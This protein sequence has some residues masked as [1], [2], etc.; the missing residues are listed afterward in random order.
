MKLLTD[1]QIRAFRQFINAHDFFYLIGHKEPDGDCICSCVA[2]SLLIDSLDKPFQLLSAGPFKRTEI[3]KYESAFSNAMQF[4]T[5]NERRRSALIMVDCSEYSRLGDIEGDVKNLDTCVIDHHKTA[6]APDN[7]L[8]F[9]DVTAPSTCSI[10]QQ[11]YE[12]VH[13][14]VPQQ[15]AE[16]LFTGVCTDTGFFRFLSTDSA[17]V[18]KATARLVS[19]GAN[20][21]ITYDYITGGKS[22]DSRKLLGAA[23]N[24]AERYLDGRLIVTCET[25]DDTQKW[26]KDGRDS[27]ALYSLLLSIQGVEAVVFVRQETEHTCTLGFRSKDTVDVSAIATQFGGG[28]HK[29]ASG[30]SCNGQLETL[31]PAIVKSFARIM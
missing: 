21:R 24:S 3:K 11:L 2:L 20:P 15:A 29:N 31:I 10:V 5:E 6:H 16:I 12:G 9:I 4:L 19:A 17:E 28:G 1:E 22:Y 25:L 27:D 18:F 30:A 26:G 13:G 14:A 23:L 7:A 8:C